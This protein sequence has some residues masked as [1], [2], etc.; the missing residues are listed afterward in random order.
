[1]PHNLGK[2]VF[3]RGWP[4]ARLSGSIATGKSIKTL[5]HVPRQEIAIVLITE[6][7]QA[8]KQGTSVIEQV[9]GAETARQ[10]VTELYEASRGGVLRYLLSNGLDAGRAEE[11]MQEAFLRLYSALQSGEELTNPRG[12]LFRVAHNLAMDVIKHSRPEAEWSDTIAGAPVE[13]GVGA[14]KELL[15]KEWN[16]SFQREIQSLSKR[17]RLCLELRAQGLRYEE[18]AKLLNVKSSTVAELLRRGFER[19]RKWNQC[20]TWNIPTHIPIR[21]QMTDF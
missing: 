14:E 2:V 8:G 20:R 4:A 19:L 18:I 10:Q 12:W 17:Q 6:S 3:K 13:A 11:V 9:A 21:I 16:E 7:A 5:Q 1:V 15:E